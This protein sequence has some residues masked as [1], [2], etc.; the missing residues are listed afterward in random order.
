MSASGVLRC[1][2]SVDL[3]TVKVDKAPLVTRLRVCPF[4]EDDGVCPIGGLIFE[5]TLGNII[6]NDAQFSHLAGGQEGV[7]RSGIEDE[8][9]CSEDDFSSFLIDCF[10]FDDN[11]HNGQSKF[12][13]RI[14]IKTSDVGKLYIGA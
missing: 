13:C 9:F 7:C 6:N 1:S 11:S 12:A 10:G 14:C 3:L 8:V 2:E 5:V 4:W